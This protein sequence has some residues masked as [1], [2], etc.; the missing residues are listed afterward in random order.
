[1]HEEEGENN[2]AYTCKPTRWH[3]EQLL[4]SHLN[5]Q[6]QLHMHGVMHDPCMTWHTHR[7]WTHPYV[8]LAALSQKPCLQESD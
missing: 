5:H 1:M 6:G 2:L 3:I 4:T 7:V 8:K